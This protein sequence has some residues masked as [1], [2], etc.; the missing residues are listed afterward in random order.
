MRSFV[1]LAVTVVFSSHAVCASP[2]SLQLAAKGIS[3]TNL[4][5]AYRAQDWAEDRPTPPGT[6][7]DVSHKRGDAELE[8]SARG[9]IGL[10]RANRMNAVEG[11]TA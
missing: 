7:R 8:D 6:S 4:A 3:S 1:I 9:L 11:F 10:G 5:R 2:N